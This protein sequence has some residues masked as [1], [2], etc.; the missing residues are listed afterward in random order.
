MGIN[1]NFRQWYLLLLLLQNLG[2]SKNPF[3]L[4]PFSPRYI[5]MGWVGLCVSLSRFLW[6]SGLPFGRIGGKV[7]DCV[8]ISVFS[9]SK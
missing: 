5:D 9:V 6:G 1:H 8:S 4:P 3:S 2:D 7:C